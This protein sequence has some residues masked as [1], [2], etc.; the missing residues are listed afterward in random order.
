MLRVTT[1]A[2]IEG[3]EREGAEI[4]AGAWQWTSHKHYL[5]GG[6]LNPGGQKR[7]MVR[8]MADVLLEVKVR[9]GGP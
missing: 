8:I 9:R 5:V 1:D 2:L 4:Q 7:P 3:E 6:G